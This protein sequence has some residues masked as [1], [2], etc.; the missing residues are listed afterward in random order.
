MPENVYVTVPEYLLQQPGHLC[1]SKAGHF[2]YTRRHYADRPAGISEFVLLYCVAGAGW[3]ADSSGKTHMSAGDLALIP[4]NIANRYGADENQP[5]QIY[6]LHFRCGEA[7][8]PL[9][10]QLA[11][12]HNIAVHH[13][14][15]RDELLRSLQRIVQV[16]T[17]PD[18]FLP[19][20]QCEC[21]GQLLLLLARLFRPQ[22]D[23]EVPSAV[24][25]AISILR[26][27]VYGHITLSELAGQL[28]L[29]KYYL[30][31][32]FQ[33]AA[34]QAP[35]ACY[36]HLKCQEASRLLLATDKTVAEISAMLCFASPYYFSE[37]FKQHTGYPPRRYRQLFSG[38]VESD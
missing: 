5:W 25:Q 3:V 7:D 19:E 35:M 22:G 31:H 10:N 4:P 6:W 1:V 17:Q 20:N 24:A 13:P 27:R 38:L 26:D 36:Q 34:G 30:S 37:R 16:L 32:L 18:G 2:T 12:M 21:A 8:F 14:A 33:Q 9:A 29:S 28:G 23:P 15:V 11:E